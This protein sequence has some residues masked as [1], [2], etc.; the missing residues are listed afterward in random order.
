MIMFDQSRRLSQPLRWDRREKTVVAVLIA[1]VVLGVCGLVAYG[2]TAGSSSAPADCIRLT[3]AST[4]GGGKLEAC[5]Q[6][7]R[8]VCASPGEVRGLED[9]LRAACRHAGFGFQGPRHGSRQVSKPRS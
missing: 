9:Q 6:R 4:L 7:A 1:C 5:G 2:L 3:F 8:E